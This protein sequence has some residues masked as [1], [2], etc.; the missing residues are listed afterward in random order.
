MMM[1]ISGL[2]MMMS[3]PGLMMDSVM[4]LE[5][6]GEEEEPAPPPAIPCLGFVPPGI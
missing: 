6:G 4:G 2:N 5:V 3:I 1:F